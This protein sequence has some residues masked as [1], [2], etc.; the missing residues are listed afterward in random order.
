MKMKLASALFAGACASFAGLVALESPAVA[1]TEQA[2]NQPPPT[3]QRRCL[4]REGQ[5]Q[6]F[7]EVSFGRFRKNAQGRDQWI[8]SA[9]IQEIVGG[10]QRDLFMFAPMSPLG[11]RTQSGVLMR[12]D[13]NNPQRVPIAACLPRGCQVLLKANNELIAALKAGNEL[14]MQFQTGNGQTVGASLT[15]S[16][17]TAAYDGP[18][19]ET[20]T[21]EAPQAGE[22][23]AAPGAGGGK[24]DAPVSNN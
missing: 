14:K 13:D 16:G 17:F 11:I 15:L 5:D 12:I 23:Q 19:A 20:R 6:V 7:C 2:E 1:Q 21:V 10:D 8:A 9:G 22:G 4:Q 24:G 3:W 18:P